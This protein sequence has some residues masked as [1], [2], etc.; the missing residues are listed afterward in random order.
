LPESLQKAFWPHDVHLAKVS[1]AGCHQLHP[2]Q[3]KMA[4]LSNKARIEICVDCHR[5]QQSDPAFNPAA[6]RLGKA[7]P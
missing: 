5:Q 7:L 6:V 4:G 1:C 3:D 2:E